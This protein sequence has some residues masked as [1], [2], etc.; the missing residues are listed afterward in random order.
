[1]S[2]KNFDDA[3]SNC[4]T[5]FGSGGYLTEPKT[6]DESKAL[7]DYAKDV[8]N[9]HPYWIG[10][11]N[12][13]SVVAKTKFSLTNHPATFKLPVCHSVEDFTSLPYVT[14]EFHSR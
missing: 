14:S 10:Y 8:L 6:A 3:Q 5:K 2:K 7:N 4:S 9:S 12:E 1:M 11:D 13:E